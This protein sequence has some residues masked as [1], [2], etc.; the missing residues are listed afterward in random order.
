MT[1]FKKNLIRL[2]CK[3]VFLITLCSVFSLSNAL[4]SLRAWTGL[5]L[6]VFQTNTTTGCH[7]GLSHVLPSTFSMIRVK[8]TKS[9]FHI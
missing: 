9:V 6:D 7:L 4:I 1:I 3:N 2:A 8:N 5:L